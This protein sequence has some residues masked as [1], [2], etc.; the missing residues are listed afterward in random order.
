M[1]AFKKLNINRATDGKSKTLHDKAK[2]RLKN[3]L[4]DSNAKRFYNN[5]ET[6]IFGTLQ[7]SIVN[8]NKRS[9][10]EYV[11]SITMDKQLNDVEKAALRRIFV[12]YL[13]LFFGTGNIYNVDSFDLLK[14]KGEDSTYAIKYILKESTKYSKLLLNIVN[15]N[16]SSAK[17]CLDS[18]LE[19][20]FKDKISNTLTVRI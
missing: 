15:E 6:E 2:N 1:A 11:L 16:Y 7:N 3:S 13:S 12:A 14:K 4:S 19:S 5:H 10:G 9:P 17:E 20:K 18:I 8:A